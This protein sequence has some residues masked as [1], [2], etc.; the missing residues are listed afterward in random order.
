MKNSTFLKDK[1]WVIG[2]DGAT[3]E[4]IMPWINAGKLPTF[5]RLIREGA[6]G[7][8][9]SKIPQSPP[10]W[11]SFMTGCNPGK[12][13]IFDWMQPRPGSYEADLANGTMCCAPAI[14]EILSFKKR[15]VG[16]VNVPM[17][18]PPIE[19]NG[20][21]ISGFEAPYHS[22]DFTHPRGLLPELEDR[23]GPYI[24]L[25]IIVE[26]PLRKTIVNFHDTISQRQKIMDYLMEKYN[27]EFFLIVFNA[28]D[29]LQHLCLQSYTDN[30]KNTAHLSALY[31]IYRRFDVILKDLLERLPGDTTLIV[32]SD[33]G[34]GPKHGTLYLDHWLAQKGWLR[35]ASSNPKLAVR[36]KWK[37]LSQRLISGLKTVIPPQLKSVLKGLTGNLNTRLE[38]A[39]IPP[40]IDW[41]N[42]QAF[43]FSQQGVYINLE[44]RYPNGLVKP[45]L[46]YKALCE[47]ITRALLDLKN[48]DDGTPVVERISSK[49]EIFKGPY[50]DLAPDLYI[51]WKDDAYFSCITELEARSLIFQR[52]RLLDMEEIVV[53]ERRDSRVGCH[54][55][56]GILLMYGEKVK[57]GFLIKNAQIEDLAPT[58]L[59]LM[60]EPIL[61]EM[62]GN[63]LRQAFKDKYWREPLVISSQ[64][65]KASQKDGAAVYSKEERESVEKKLRD[66]GYF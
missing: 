60:K 16:V 10:A 48:P 5:S 30:G 64:D 36:Q 52:L 4:L 7:I 55:Q 14:W 20:F 59:S 15:T 50:Q 8:L 58:I 41:A 22:R 63:V 40:V 66:L 35:Y 54:R 45:G 17:T 28:A 24:R 2:L 65:V 1:V 38:K 43:S 33:H 21:I 57:P 34:A 44:G 11:A 18:Y 46:E 27:P 39:L 9:H 13:G 29:I 56:E 53:S 37:K 12:H 47:D 42:T 23:F 25:P 51:Y 61:S 49:E 3:F 32:V 19:V 26:I 62:D 6:H 31:S